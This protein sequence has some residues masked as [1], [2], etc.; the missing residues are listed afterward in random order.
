MNVPSS[1]WMADAACAGYPNPEAFFP[2]SQGRAAVVEAQEALAVCAR[3]PVVA[4][5]AAYQKA[6]GS[7]GVWGSTLV[8]L[9]CARTP[10]AFRV[11]KARCGTDSGYSKHLLKGEKPCHVCFAAY[12]ARRSPGGRSKTRRWG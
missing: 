1:N 12:S 11:S 3:C 9:K 6:T 8:S 7:V 4:Q 5:C 10:E 2:R